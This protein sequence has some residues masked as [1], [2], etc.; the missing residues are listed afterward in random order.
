MFNA[1]EV[2]NISK[3]YGKTKA[4]DDISFTVNPGEIFGLV[5]T[6]GA[7]KSTF[8]K[9][10]ST[11]LQPSSG[12]VSVYGFDIQKDSDEIRKLIAYLPE[13]SGVYGYMKGIDFLKYIAKI[14]DKKNYQDVL[15]RGIEIADLDDD[16]N[17]KVNDYSKGM[18]RKISI[19]RVLMVE[20]K[21]LILDEFT[22][23]LD[24]INAHKMRK[25]VKAHA[26]NGNSVLISTHNML[27]VEMLCDRIALINEG[28]IY[29]IGTP[30]GLESKYNCDNISDVFV[31]VLK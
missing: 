7:G 11:I 23:G 17:K 26:C 16:I 25:R 13:E 12:N 21:L 3:S 28:R 29:E 27:E 19:A 10:L 18:T 4:L 14:F 20:S 30:K 2:N 5:G 6:N 24:V 31:K 8:L 1:I 22:S 9:I 15:N